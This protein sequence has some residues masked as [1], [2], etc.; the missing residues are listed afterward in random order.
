MEKTLLINYHAVFLIALKTK[1]EMMN[2]FILF[3]V[4]E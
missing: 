4:I 2:K 1:T 3:N